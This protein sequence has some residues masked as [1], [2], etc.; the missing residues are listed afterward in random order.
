MHGGGSG[1]EPPW[2]HPGDRRDASTLTTSRAGGSPPAGAARG[3]TP[4][5]R[6]HRAGGDSGGRRAPGDRGR[7]WRRVRQ[8]QLRVCVD[9]GGEG[10]VG[11]TRGPV[12][13]SAGVGEDRR[14]GRTVDA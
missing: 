12:P 3:E 14:D 4:P 8:Q 13:A 1:F 9:D 11:A 5:G 7:A 6:A 10:D 2:L